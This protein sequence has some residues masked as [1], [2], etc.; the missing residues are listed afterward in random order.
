MG[1]ACRKPG[2]DFQDST[3]P[4]HHPEHGEPPKSTEPEVFLAPL[5]AKV[6]RTEVQ[7][8]HVPDFSHVKQHLASVKDGESAMV[9][10]LQLNFP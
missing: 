8:M 5:P 7:R 9:K 6:L 2:L 10:T 3:V 1:F 4:E